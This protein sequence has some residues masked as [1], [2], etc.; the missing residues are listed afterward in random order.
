MSKISIIVPVYNVSAYLAECLN[1]IQNQTV[2]EWEAILIDDGST[3]SS[4]N[5]CDEYAAKDDRFRVIH[6]A[7][8]GAANAKNTGLDNATGEY[9]A[10]VDSDDTVSPVW[11]ET[12]FN[13]IETAD[14][15]E[16][17]FDRHYLSG[18]EFVPTPDVG[19]FSADEYICQYLNNWQCSLFWNKIFRS[20]IIKNI[21]F[22]KERR[23]ID[24]E[25][26]TYKAVTFA[27]SI[28]RISDVLYHY[29][30]R[31]SSAVCSEKNKQQITDDSLE[32]LIERYKWISDK[33][34]KQQKTYLK[35]DVD[36][37]FYFARDFLFT[38]VTIK[39]FRKIARYYLVQS[40]LHFPG[41][42]TLQYALRLQIIKTASFR[43]TLNTSNIQPTNNLFQ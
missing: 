29:R 4:G 3:D 28:V 5:I 22:R 6:Q 24:D 8:A 25:F 31:K 30:Q 11:L 20:D 13:A 15:V 17:G 39:N 16:Y 23:C 36:I 40:L 32:I 43:I 27:R 38:D 41:R 21:R 42:I 26:F 19:I 33:F 10:F 37:L 7:N 12:C 9:I 2:A 1:S 34:P 18:Y 35:H 14:V